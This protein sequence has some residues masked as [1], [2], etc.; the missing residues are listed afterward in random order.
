MLPFV[1]YELVKCLYSMVS[2]SNA[3]ACCTCCYCTG[4]SKA[5]MHLDKLDYKLVRTLRIPGINNS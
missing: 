3:F 2:M 1:Y 5:V 4:I